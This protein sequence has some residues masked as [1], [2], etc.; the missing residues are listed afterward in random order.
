MKKFLK[1]LT[2]TVI[3]AALAVGMIACGQKSLYDTL[4][5]SG[6]SVRV[7]YDAGGAFVNGT[8]NVTI[9]EAYSKDDVT[10]VGGK[11]GIMILDPQSALR[12]EDGAFKLSKS[13]ETNNYF[14]SGWYLSREVRKDE[15]GNILDAYG[16]PVS[17]SGREQGYVYKDKWSFTTDLIDP[18][19]LENGEMTLYAS[20]IPFFTYEIYAENE[21]GEYELLSTA[22]RIDFT[23]PKWNK[24]TGDITMGD[25]PRVSDKTFAGA[26]F[27]A[28]MTEAV[29]GIIDG[30]VAFVDIEKGIAKQTTVKIYTKWNSG[31]WKRLY[32]AQ[33]LVDEILASGNEDVIF[34]LGDDL[35]FSGVI[36]PESFADAVFNGTVKGNGFVI[37]NLTDANGDPIDNFNDIFGGIGEDAVIENIVVENP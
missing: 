36:I 37:R 13:D 12:G 33:K 4:G 22:Q 29:E 21:N 28:D 18:T 30:D 5:E 27:D 11:S 10:S 19:K 20:W 1:K 2:V 23:L 26:Y 25:M 15:N 9:V 24:A 32:S 8:Q 14:S 35:D 34:E 31:R 3:L 16:I 17:V 7:R 6:Y